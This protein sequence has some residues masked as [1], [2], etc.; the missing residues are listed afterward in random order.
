MC[1]LLK[2]CWLF[3]KNT[4]WNLQH[5]KRLSTEVGYVRSHP[6]VVKQ[7]KRSFCLVSQKT[8]TSS[9]KIAAKKESFCRMLRNIGTKNRL[10]Q[11]SWKRFS[12]WT[13]LSPSPHR[14]TGSQGCSAAAGI[15]H[16]APR[17]TGKRSCGLPILLWAK[18]ASVRLLRL[19]RYAQHCL[20]G[21]SA[22]L[23]IASEKQE[24][25][26]RYHHESISGSLG[27][28]LDLASRIWNVDV[29][30][31][32]PGFW[33]VTHSVI[34]PWNVGW[35]N[36][37]FHC[38]DES[39]LLVQCVSG[40]SFVSNHCVLSEREGK[41]QRRVAIIFQTTNKF[42]DSFVSKTKTGNW[43]R[44]PYNGWL[45]DEIQVSLVVDEVHGF[46]CEG[47]PGF[48]HAL[49]VHHAHVR[50]CSDSFTWNQ[51]FNPKS[52]WVWFRQRWVVICW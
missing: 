20:K 42:L 28:R 37:D 46:S 32:H 13:K 23:L 52:V 19:A 1:P 39:V 31:F 15:P 9:W 26:N 24:A 8:R 36:G 45:E 21:F 25:T 49:Q 3:E 40:Q 22:I 50:C 35:L 30:Y 43:T 4:C 38:V 10:F 18:R 2:F 47:Q 11:T 33:W 48:W 7:W 29:V 12:P 27:S 34:P 14:M 44:L 41:Q 51:E 17:E 6:P 16:C 5:D